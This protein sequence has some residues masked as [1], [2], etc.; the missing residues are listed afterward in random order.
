MT[1]FPPVPWLTTHAV[2]S[3]KELQVRVRRQERAEPLLPPRAGRRQRRRPR[4]LHR[5]GTE[6]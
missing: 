4:G 3:K 6:W 5:Q 1:N 2:E